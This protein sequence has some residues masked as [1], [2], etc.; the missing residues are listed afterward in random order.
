MAVDTAGPLPE[1]PRGNI[2]LLVLVC[3]FTRFCFLRA[4]PN[5]E[6]ATI[7]AVLFTIFCEIGFPTILQS[8]NGTEYVNDILKALFGLINA[9]HRLI[10]PYNPRANGVAERWVQLAV[11]AIRKCLE[12][13]ETDWDLFTPGTQLALN[14]RVIS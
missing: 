4:L 13:A 3:L 8:D 9:A 14:T 1:T 5:K 6:A 12:G 2:Y 10:T 11:R 7:A